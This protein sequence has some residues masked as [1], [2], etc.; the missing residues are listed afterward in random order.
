G[1]PPAADESKPRDL[2]THHTFTPPS[3]RKAWEDRAGEIR[4][5]IL[6]SAGLLPMPA[7]TPMHPRVTGRIEAEDYTIENVALETRPGFFLCGNLYRPK[8]K[9]GPFPGIVNPH[10]HWQ[11][12]RLE[13]QPDVPKADPNGKM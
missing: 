5:Q 3:N 9:K 1:Q 11:H 12:G 4:R 13:M 2:D 6:V 10:G 8:G 7:K